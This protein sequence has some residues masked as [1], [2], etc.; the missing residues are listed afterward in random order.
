MK[1][2]QTKLEFKNLDNAIHYK[3]TMENIFQG[4]RDYSFKSDLVSSEDGFYVI[5]TLNFISYEQKN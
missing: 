4:V 3:S 1:T 2:V 5:Q